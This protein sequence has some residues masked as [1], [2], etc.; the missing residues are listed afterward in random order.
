MIRCMYLMCFF[1]DLNRTRRDGHTS[2]GPD[3]DVEYV[4]YEGKEVVLKNQGPDRVATRTIF[5][6]YW[7]AISVRLVTGVTVL[8]TWFVI[9]I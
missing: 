4:E 8:N 7:H 5:A 2:R 6:G 3:R 1:K 9:V